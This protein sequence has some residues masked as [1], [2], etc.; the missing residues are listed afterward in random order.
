MRETCYAVT[1][2]DLRS[3]RATLER[4]PGVRSVETSGPTLHLFADPDTA[5]PRIPG[6]EYREIVPSLEDVFIAHVR[7]EDAN[8]AA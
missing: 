6:A 5:L 1:A 8:R 2:P 3:A 4:A 7:Q